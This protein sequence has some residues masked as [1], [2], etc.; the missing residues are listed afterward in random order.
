MADRLLA[1]DG[2]IALD[3]FT[4][5]H[6]SQN[7]A[8]IFKYLYT[9]GTSLTP[10][11]VTDEKA[12]LCRKSMRAFYARFVLERLLAEMESRGISP[13]CLARTE[14]HPDYR[15]F[16]LRCHSGEPGEKFYGLDIYRD[17]FQV[18]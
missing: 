12:Y 13:V 2:L 6:Y 16:Y 4:N 7:I 18:P 15:A 14:L 1:Q 9:T 17:F 5:L 3:D 11:V 8:A 10:L